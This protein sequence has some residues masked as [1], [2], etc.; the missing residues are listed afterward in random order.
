[1][2]LLASL[3]SPSESTLVVLQDWATAKNTGNVKHNAVLI[4]SRML[5]LSLNVA[6]NSGTNL[7]FSHQTIMQYGI[8]CDDILC[9][10]APGWRGISF[11]DSEY[12]IGY[13]CRAS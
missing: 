8:N 11:Y 7:T 5:S 13:S 4:D 3:Y 10:F 6:K 2:S 1:M 9:K 12:A